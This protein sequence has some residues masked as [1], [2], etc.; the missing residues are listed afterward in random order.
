MANPKVYFDITI[1]G[2]A[3]GRI[4]IEVGHKKRLNFDGSCAL[5]S[6]RLLNLTVF[7]SLLIA[8][9]CF[10]I[11]RWAD[12]EAVFFPPAPNCNNASS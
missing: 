4:V 1:D 3:A 8:C 12:G 5:A 7:P 6:H 11:L 9:K 10:S 2:K